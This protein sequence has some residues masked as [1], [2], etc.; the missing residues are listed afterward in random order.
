ML[1]YNRISCFIFILSSCYSEL[2]EPDVLSIANCLYS[3]SWLKFL[4]EI[5][6]WN[7]WLKFLIEIPDIKFRLKFDL[8]KEIFNA[9][10]VVPC[11]NF[12]LKF[13]LNCK[14]LS[15]YRAQI[16]AWNLIWIN[17]AKVLYRTQVPD[18]NLNKE[19]FK[20][21]YRCT[22]LITIKL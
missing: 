21:S 16:P 7:S 1:I 13:D 18:W 19:V 20:S 5:P 11:S 17:A 22:E 9:A 2:S 15:L 14:Q 6:D 3:N 8:N 12:C 10:N 4:I